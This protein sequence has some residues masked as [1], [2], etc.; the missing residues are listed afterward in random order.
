MWGWLGVFIAP[1]TKL[2]V[3]VEAV[4]RMVHRT[5]RCPSHVTRTLGFQPLELCLL[6]PPG[7][8]WRTG[9][10][11]FS[12]RCAMTRVPDF[13]APDCALWRAFNAPAGDRWR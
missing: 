3:W 11:L 13:C 9:H 2:A 10:P 4:C 6:G 5:V 12:V 1:T 7:V 8:W